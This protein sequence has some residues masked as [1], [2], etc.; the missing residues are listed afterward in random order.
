VS[1]GDAETG[2]G[3]PNVSFDEVGKSIAGALAKL[4]EF[5]FLKIVPTNF[6]AETIALL[7][8]LPFKLAADL[9]VL[10]A[11]TIVDLLGTAKSEVNQLA[12][13]TLGEVFGEEFAGAGGAGGAAAGSA[14]VGGA[15]LR[16]IMGP[17]FDSFTPISGPTVVP[18]EQFLGTLLG[19]GIRAWLLEIITDLLPTP[20]RPAVFNDL[21]DTVLRTTG[22]ARLSRVALQPAIQSA[23]AAPLQW[24][25]H[26][27]L[28]PTLLNDG[29][30]V[31][32]WLRG[33]WS[34]QQLIDELAAKGYSDQRIE[35]IINDVELRLGPSDVTI[36]VRNQVWTYEEGH[37]YLM[38]S[39]YPDPT[40]SSILEVDNL[41]QLDA[42]RAR[43][44]SAYELRY[45][46]NQIDDGQF[47]LS[48]Q[49]LGL[50]PQLITA[51]TKILDVEK[52]AGFKV[53]DK[54]QLDAALSKNV[55]SLD[56][57]RN[58]LVNLGYNAADALILEL[59]EQATLASKEEAAKAKQAAKDAQAAAKAA[60]KQQ[61][62]ADKKARAEAAAAKAAQAAQARKDAAAARQQT[63]LE[64]QQLL[65]QQAAARRDQIAKAQAAKLLSSAQAAAELAQVTAQEQAGAAAVAADKAIQETSAAE[66]NQLAA[67][68]VTAQTAAGKA[69]AQASAATAQADAQEQALTERR[70]ERIAK[71]EA[72]RAQ[73]QSEL[74]AGLLTSGTAQKKLDTIQT[75]EQA[76]IKAERLDELAIARA[77]KQ[78]ATIA[79]RGAG[80]AAAA[81][82]KK[83]LIPAASARKSAIL[84]SSAAALAGVKAA[85]GSSTAAAKARAAAAAASSVQTAATQLDTLNAQLLEQ[86][87]AFEKTHS[88]GG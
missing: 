63:L 23:I 49:S 36:L 43:A 88:P 78:A 32:A 34:E 2:G 11:K 3:S 61:A 39:G 27:S 37:Q 44:I 55:I 38:D 87:Q 79:A 45:K 35:D 70:Q 24:Y 30:A 19:V 72:Q 59:T 57:W 13:T 58:G 46:R 10:V 15:L 80:T 12:A 50:F 41:K 68:D 74:D 25:V 8:A 18:A 6:V 75:N 33:K 71:Y 86:L 67:A 14:A 64:K 73:V 17:D 51:W 84:S 77:R 40:A 60:A 26:D 53:L 22:L 65:A 1:N 48:L 28:R 16:A 7:L 31:K 82:A 9:V 83:G 21:V 52:L 4:G 47:A 29:Q 20:I 5:T 69:A 66:Q 62:A 81:V 42:L 56:E 76:D 54:A 85:S